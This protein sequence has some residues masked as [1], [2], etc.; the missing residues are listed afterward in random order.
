MKTLKA[1]KTTMLDNPVVKAE[2]DALA[3]EFEIARKLVPTHSKHD[4]DDVPDPSELEQDWLRM[5]CV[6]GRI[7]PNPALEPELKA[8]VTRTIDRLGLDAPL[9]REMRVRWFD[10]Y[11]AIP[12][13]SDYLR[14]KSAFVWAE[15]KRQGLLD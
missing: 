4:H 5:E 15:A 9:C 12:L 2:Y 13:P 7:F 6:T 11:R 14:K 10:E 8:R 1:L 3:H